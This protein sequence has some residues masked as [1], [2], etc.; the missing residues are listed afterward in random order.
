MITLYFSATGNSLTVAKKIGG[1]LISI[2]QAVKN[3]QYKF[4]DDVIGLV[5]PTYCC[6]PP[7]IVRDFMAKAKLKADYLFAVATYGNAMGKGG[8]G[9]EMLE[10]DKLAKAAGYSFSYLNS[11][12]MVDN[13]I[14]NFDIE[15]EIKKIPSKRIDENII[16]TIED[17]KNRKTYIKN[18]G[19]MGKMITAICKGL[20]A[21]QDKGL[22]AQKFLVDDSCTGCAT[23]VKVCPYGNISVRDGIPQFGTNCMSCYACIH[24][25]PHK[26]IHKKSEKSAKRWRNPEITLKEIIA[27][28]YQ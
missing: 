16:L 17:I 26:A 15:K 10:F 5:F 13:F 23:C 19:F 14:D 3:D 2:P 24:N 4:E 21:S 8:D 28:N 7:K 18:P 6:Y 25:C 22:A 1:E 20:V 27:A 12:L 9:S 11:I